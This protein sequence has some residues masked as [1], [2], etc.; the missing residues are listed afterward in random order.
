MNALEKHEI[1]EIE[2][3]DKLKNGRVLQGLVFGGGTMLR[4][5][6]EMK[7]FSADLDFWKITDVDDN[8][9][10]EELQNLLRKDYEITDAQIKYYTILVEVHSSHFPKR[11]KIEIRREPKDC[12]FE[13]KIAY[14]PFSTRQVLVTAHTL[15]QAL[16]YKIA[17]LLDRGEIRDAFDIEFILR[18]GIPLP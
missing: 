2:V 11:L 7:R 18:Q 9:L 8:K 4:L 16:E 5:C 3:L 17:A 6:H 10:F 15:K 1:F 14:S 12:E 13:Q